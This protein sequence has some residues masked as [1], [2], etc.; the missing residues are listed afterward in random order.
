MLKAAMERDMQSRTFERNIKQ[1]GEVVMN[2]RGLLGKLD[3]SS[4]KEAFIELYR[5]LAAEQGI[6]FSRDE[7]LIAVQEQKHGSNWVIPT[8]VQRMI[9][10]RF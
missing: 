6:H 5:K 4:D 1:F 2:D 3:E 10:E 9:A 8:A 7:L